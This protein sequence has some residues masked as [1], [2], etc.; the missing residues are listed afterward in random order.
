MPKS[1]PHAAGVFDLAVTKHLHLPPT[2]LSISPSIVWQYKGSSKVADFLF[3]KTKYKPITSQLLGSEVVYLG[4]TDSDVFT[5][6]F[7]S[8]TVEYPSCIQG[9]V[10]SHF[11]QDV[12][13]SLMANIIQSQ[14]T[15]ESLMSSFPQ[16]HVGVFNVVYNLTCISYRFQGGE[17]SCTF[18]LW[19]YF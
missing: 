2:Y 17:T 10:M 19:R 5:F 15:Q 3:L 6:L 7:I 9:H 8:M 16:D 11:L 12:Q 13:A 14:A 4:A 1:L 18:R